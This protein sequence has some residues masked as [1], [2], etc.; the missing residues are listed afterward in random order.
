MQDPQS[1]YGIAI[2]FVLT[3]AG[4][5]TRLA[6]LENLDKKILSNLNWL[7]ALACLRCLCTYSQYDI[8]DHGELLS[9]SV[10]VLNCYVDQLCLVV[11]IWI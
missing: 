11:V 5:S 9:K 6:M 2:N 4:L 3:Q 1:I 8:Y 10:S 7:L